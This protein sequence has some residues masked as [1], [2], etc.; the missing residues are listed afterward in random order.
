MEAKKKKRKMM[1]LKVKKN[2][3]YSP[4]GCS[5]LG[6]LHE[7][8]PFLRVTLIVSIASL[9]VVFSHDDTWNGN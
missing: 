9:S 8:H 1:M 6:F 3:N 7:R 2:G 4:L 5:V